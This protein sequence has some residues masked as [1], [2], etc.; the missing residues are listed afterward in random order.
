MEMKAL[1]E[2]LKRAYRADPASAKVVLSAVGCVD[3]Q[4]VACTLTS[5]N[6]SRTAGLHPKTGGDGSLACS[7]EMLLEALVAC[8]GVTCAAVA[9]AMQLEVT[10]GALRAEG[11]WDARGTLGVSREAPVGFEEIRLAFELQTAAS[12]AQ[13]E[14]LHELTERYCVVLQSLRSQSPVRATLRRATPGQ[15]R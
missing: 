11:D 5:G 3:F 8:A 9:N 6:G 4:R 7:G 1:Q 2:P 15:A 14:R 12:D 13:L 10:G